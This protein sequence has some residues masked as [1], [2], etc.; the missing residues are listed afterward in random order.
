MLKSEINIKNKILSDLSQSDQILNIKEL[1]ENYMYK[2]EPVCYK[3]DQSSTRR[4]KFQQLKPNNSRLQK[5]GIDRI[6]I[7][8]KLS[9]ESIDSEMN[10]VN[11]EIHMS[12]T[13]SSKKFCMRSFL[14][15]PT[16][17][18]KKSSTPILTKSESKLLNEDILSQIDSFDSSEELVY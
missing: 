10:N 2:K 9:F 8:S 18:I 1:K 3:N 16:K 6:N 15:M 5:D 17:K 11:S 4:Y 7:K 12:Q 14:C 13:L